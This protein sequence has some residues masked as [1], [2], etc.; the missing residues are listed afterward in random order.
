MCDTANILNKLDKVAL[1]FVAKSLTR[2]QKAVRSLGV[3]QF[4]QPL[5][6]LNHSSRFVGGVRYS[7]LKLFGVQPYS[8]LK[9][10]LKYVTL[11]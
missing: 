3:S 10:L 7:V 5:Y 8:F 2:G 1:G 4:P 11:L 6:S 9:S